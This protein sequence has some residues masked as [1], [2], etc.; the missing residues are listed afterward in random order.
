MWFA[1]IDFF[2]VQRA[3]PMAMAM[4]HRCVPNASNCDYSPAWR[5]RPGKYDAGRIAGLQNRETVQSG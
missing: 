4:L 3:A 5:K 1:R 2:E